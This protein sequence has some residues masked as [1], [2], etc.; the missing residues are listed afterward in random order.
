MIRKERGHI[1]T[2]CDNCGVVNVDQEG[3]R[4]SFKTFRKAWDEL[5]ALG[6]KAKR[7]PEGGDYN[8]FCPNCEAVV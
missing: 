3:E 5:L 4:A 8:H 6:W 2:T 1:V 7:K